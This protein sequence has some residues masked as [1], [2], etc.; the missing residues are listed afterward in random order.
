MSVDSLLTQLMRDGRHPT[1]G[2]CLCLA[3]DCPHCLGT[4][5]GIAY[6]RTCQVPFE[7]SARVEWH[8]HA[9]EYPPLESIGP[10]GAVSA[11]TIHCDVVVIGQ[12]SAGRAAA[13]DARATGAHV[14]TLD[15]G[16]GQDAIGIYP[17]PLVVA[18][19]ATGMLHFYPRG[20]IIVATGAAEIQ[21]AVPGNHLRG[22]MTA[23]AASQLAAS[24]IPLGRVVAV[25]TPPAGVEYE[26]ATGTLVRFEA[27]ADAARVGAVVGRD[28]QGVEHRYECDTASLGLGFTPRDALLRMARGM[29]VRGVGDVLRPADL[30]PC[31]IA[32]VVCTCTGVTVDDLSSVHSR[33]F[34]E[35]E[36]VKRATLAGTGPCQGSACVPHIRAFLTAQGAALQPP[37]TSR[38][39]TRQLTIGEVAAGAHHA[40]TPRTALDG[41]HRSMGATMER[42]GGWW[43]P[44]HYGDTA[45]EYDAVRQRVSICDVSTL[46]KFQVSGPGAVALLEHLYPVTIA[47]LAPGRS[48]YAFLLDERGYVVDDGMVCRESETRFTLTFT[49]GGAT[50]AES[51][52]RDWA[53]SLGLD[54]R[55]M[56][57]TFS[58][59]A[60]NVTGPLA[61]SLL[62]RAGVTHPPAFL[63]HVNADVAG[64][65]CHIFRLSFTGEV[66][67]ELHHT[68]E[69]SVRLWRRLLELGADLGVRPHGL[70]ALLKLRLEKGH[71]LVG[72]DTDFDSSLR[73]LGCEWAVQLGKPAFVGRHAVVRTNRIPLDRQLCG[74]EMEGTAPA[75]GAVIWN[76]AE[77]AGVVT[78]SAWSPTL[79]KSIMLGWLRLTDNALPNDVTIDDRPARRVT[80]PFFDP[81]GRRARA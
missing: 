64:V 12:G 66:S 35:L 13:D 81:E 31:P 62:A 49:S 54:V 61:S 9:C 74:L 63:H 7:P 19:T 24:R 38:P 29:N 10:R 73:R 2:G 16:N 5:G 17:G 22:L 68:A 69:D 32:G 47:T 27:G 33:G 39:V 52:V 70:E 50:F 79:G 56:N 30:P 48:R 71:L 3:G 41:E 72:Q 67:F 15:S 14:E 25:G 36:L 55:I 44:W 11:R 80:T 46:G 59:G 18:R 20:E 58:A 40:A 8:P 28:A 75:E 45:A 1:A 23:R 77:L 34:H 43:R 65:P 60:I 4:V 21:P 53:E 6:V 37:F 57:R 51:W 26:V 78:S 76:G 42:L